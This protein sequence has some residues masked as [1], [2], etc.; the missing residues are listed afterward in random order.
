MTVFILWTTVVKKF[1]SNT[2]YGILTL[3]KQIN[4]VINIT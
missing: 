2:L 1:L 3:C 4:L